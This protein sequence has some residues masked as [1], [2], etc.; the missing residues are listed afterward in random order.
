[1]PF[2]TPKA[3]IP[4][5]LRQYG[6]QAEL[7]RN[8]VALHYQQ[9]PA[10]VLRCN[11]SWSRSFI[12]LAAKRRFKLSVKGFLSPTPVEQL[13]PEDAELHLA[14]RDQ[15]AVAESLLCSRECRTR[16]RDCHN[17]LHP[18]LPLRFKS[19]AAQL[20][21]ADSSDEEEKAQV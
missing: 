6:C 2:L 7:V 5:P 1:M 16:Q 13:R 18:L 11:F 20:L 19:A 21:E 17:V 12:S 15:Q 9:C 3:A 10:F 8:R 14:L 4:C